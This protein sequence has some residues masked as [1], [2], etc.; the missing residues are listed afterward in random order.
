MLNNGQS[1]MTEQTLETRY[2]DDP[3]LLALYERKLLIRGWAGKKDPV[4]REYIHR[5]RARMP[6]N[7]TVH[8]NQTACFGRAVS[9]VRR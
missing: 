7:G 6:Q 3:E 2:K 1:R 8:V 9:L 4:E 5:A